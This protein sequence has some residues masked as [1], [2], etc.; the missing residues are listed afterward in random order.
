MTVI[1]IN[2][3]EEISEFPHYTKNDGI[4]GYIVPFGD[5]VY[6]FYVEEDTEINYIIIPQYIVKQ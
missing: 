3:G 1:H 6:F 5:K 2:N 4:Y